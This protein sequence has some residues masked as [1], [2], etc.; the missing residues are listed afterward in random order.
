MEVTRRGLLIGTGAGGALLVG[1]VLS[2]RDYGLPLAAGRGETA[3]NAWI[4]IAR[5]G[6]VT[7]AVP[8]CEMGQ[9]VTTLLPQIV[10]HELGADWRQIAV[11]P[12]AASGAYANSALAAKWSALWM[13][14]FSA[15][16]AAPDALLA[17]RWAQSEAFDA[18]A[19]GTTLA[20][21][22][23]PARA[24]A[25]GARAL[26][27]MAAADRWGIAWEECEAKEGFIVHGAQRLRFGELAARAARF[28]PP[29]PPV[30]LPAPLSESARDVVV[31]APLRFPRLD[32]PAKA[33]GSAQ[34]AGD[35]RLPGMVFA[36]IRH[37]PLGRARLTHHDAAAA[38]AVPGFLQA[39]TGADW[40]AATATDGWAAERALA[41][42]A[43]R[44]HA[45]NVPDSARIAAA[46]DGE[47][48]RGSAVRV[49]AIGDP[50]AVIADKPDLAV[51]YA[52]APALHAAIETASAAARFANGRLE[53]W[54][55]SQAPEAA[56][57]A[58]AA[59]L[60]L[61]LR[62]VVLYPC[63]AGGSFD[64]RLEHR[65]AVEAA[66]IARA[67]RRPVSLVYSRWQEQLTALPRTPVQAVLAAATARSGEIAAWRARLALPATA[68][69]FGKRLFGGEDAQAALGATDQADA[70][71]V[72]GA[73]P[74][75]A[76][77]HRAVDH[78]ATGIALPTGR[79]RGNAHGYTAFF[80]ESFVDELAHR[81]K[82]EPLSYRM[83]MLGSDLRLAQC[84]QRAAAL[85]EWDGGGGGSGQGIACHA[86]GGM[87][88]G[89]SS[90]GGRIACVAVARRDAGGVRVDRLSA[91][92]DIGRIVNLDIARQQIEGGLV[93]GLGLALGAATRYRRGEPV[94]ARLGA[95]SLPRL[96]DCPRIEVEFI[97]SGGDPFDPGELGVAVVA[98]AV[99]NALFSATGLRFR[100][101]PFNALA[102]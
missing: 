11:E 27:A 100:S 70:L 84:L 38:K 59:A 26:L 29:S 3:F 63:L 5:D 79:L 4:K 6:V 40:L 93:F 61:G 30:L 49:A 2:P 34:F 69:E 31:E 46:L 10:A 66:L 21:Y 64:L 75:Y 14:A 43:P 28:T 65:H 24:A 81:A 18:T 55:A 16:A 8:Q 25:A 92:V 76:I 86:M 101:L 85:G 17:R 54:L 44:F 1:Y 35:V 13:P 67:L 60:G 15:L 7:V 73:L 96:A 41:A 80:T 23:A 53:L 98:P 39:V 90:G 47:L 12:A 20:A 62:D 22:E 57:R 82:R 36:A 71:A 77:A 50:D 72:E 99:A 32:L 52:V 97:E 74:P 68:R 83:E 89:Q 33:D 58:V 94:T 95:M 91:A 42:M 88:A 51:R 19:D 45:E 56:R 48:H 37:A 102:T 78:V 9:G 87:D